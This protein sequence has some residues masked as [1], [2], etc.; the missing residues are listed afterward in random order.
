MAPFG[1]RGLNSGVQDVENAAWKIAFAHDGWAPES[2]LESYHDERHAAALENL[3]VTGAT[4]RFLVP[5]TDDEL[6]A[7]RDAL[8]AASR[9]SAAASRVDSGRLAEPFWYTGS[10]LTTPDPSRPA[11]FR[12]PRG[13]LPATAPGVIIPDAP[14]KLADRPAVTRL[15][16]IARDGLLALTS[17]EVDARATEAVLR[18]AV[19]SPCRAYSIREIDAGGELEDVLG[20]RAGET[21]LI[22]PD[23]HLAAIVPGVDWQAIAAAARRAVGIA[24]D[25]ELGVAQP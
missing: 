10:P 18:D 17:V 1:A 16:E 11:P 7:R 23:A 4:M 19:A 20:A 14:I 5:H 21:L 12:P 13:Q 15:R 8:E 22:R 25:T 24:A 2:L 3:E 9:D 6:T